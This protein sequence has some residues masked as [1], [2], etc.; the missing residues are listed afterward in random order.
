MKKKLS[1]LLVI[2]FLMASV[3]GSFS[4][5]AFDGAALKWD[6]KASTLNEIAQ[7]L[8]YDL[9][10]EKGDYKPMYYYFAKELWDKGLFLGSNGSF[11]LDKPLTRAQGIVMLLR[12]L[13]KEEAAKSEKH[14]CPF[15][16]VPNWAKDYVGYA[17]HNGL[18]GGY[19][20]KV[21]GAN[22]A[23]TAN[24]YLTFVLRALGYND[25]QGDFVWNKA[26]DKAME[27]GLVGAS[28]REQYMRSNLFLR[29]NVAVISHR[30]LFD[31]D[32]KTGKELEDNIV[33]KKPSGAVPYATMAEKV[34]AEVN[35]PKPNVPVV[36][37][38][39]YEK[40]AVQQYENVDATAVRKVLKE[41][42]KVL[43]L[44]Y[45]NVAAR[46]DA[47]EDLLEKAGFR[48]VGD[49]KF[50]AERITSVTGGIV[51]VGT[52]AW[53]CDWYSNGKIQVVCGQVG[54]SFVVR[55]Y[56]GEVDTFDVNA[57]RAFYQTIKS[58]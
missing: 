13:G 8:N 15:Q 34:A 56:E 52:K 5:A 28:C 21:F 2:M 35:V 46:E 38:A 12:L 6:G 41:D 36:L 18:A 7:K 14:P 50:E 29:D 4:Q 37:G 57:I 45:S 40:F 23:M 55:I 9:V 3:F 20:D 26:A 22:D 47:Y 51:Q 25:K 54:N 16:D 33:E 49:V 1:L 10:D 32:T 11:D 31:V 58:N 44:A 43:F 19:S 42:T 30:A 39:N 48:D 53:E 27:I 17:A 24:Q